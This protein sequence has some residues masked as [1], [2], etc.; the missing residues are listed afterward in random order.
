MKKKNSALFEWQK[1]ANELGGTCHKCSRKTDYLTVDHIVPASFI[2]MLGLKEESYDDDWNFQLL[3]RA[4]NKLKGNLFD[5]TNPKTFE[6]LKRYVNI[7]Q[8]FYKL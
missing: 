2:V 6:N 1:K 8:E 5:F 7:T 4:C 3:C